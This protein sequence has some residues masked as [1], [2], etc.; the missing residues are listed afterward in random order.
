M[1]NHTVT[2]FFE[3]AALWQCVDFGNEIVHIIGYDMLLQKYTKLLDQYDFNAACTE[4]LKVNG[5]CTNI[6]ERF[7]PNRLACW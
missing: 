1:V 5:D 7:S 4:T 2:K 3:R 6:F